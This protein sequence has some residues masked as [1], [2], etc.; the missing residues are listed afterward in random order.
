MKYVRQ[1][2]IEAIRYQEL[3][4]KL[5]EAKQQITRKDVVDLLRVTPPQAY[6]ILQK[7][8]RSGLLM[9]KGS[10]RSTY[11]CRGKTRT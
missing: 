10:T 1:T 5:A 3:I 9:K 11:Y 8:T 6:R 7:M 4:V 2:D